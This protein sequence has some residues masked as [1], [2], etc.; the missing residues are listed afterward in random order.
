MVSSISEVFC[1]DLCLHN[2]QVSWK[3]ENITEKVDTAKISWNLTPKSL[4][5]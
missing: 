1:V 5:S 3:L 2:V 4:V